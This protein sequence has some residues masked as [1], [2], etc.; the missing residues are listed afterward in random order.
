MAGPNRHRP[1]AA[2]GGATVP[3][4]R[5]RWASRAWLTDLVLLALVLLL[6]LAPRLVNLHTYSGLF[7]EGIRTEQLFLMQQGY[8]PFSQI[9][10]AQGPLLLDTLYPLYALYDRLLDPSLLAAR[11]VAVTYSLVGLAGVYWLGHQLAGRTG[12]LVAAL[13]LAL[14]P[15]YLEGSRLALAEVPAL[16]PA[17]LALGCAQR[18]SLRGASRWLWLAGLLLTMSLLMK[19]ITLA[20]APA[21]ALAALLRG[22]RGL[23][24]LVAVGLGMLALSALAIWLL[25]FS[26]VFEQIWLYRKLAQEAEPW[27]LRKNIEAIRVGLGYEPLALLPLA[28][29]GGLALLASDWRRMLPSLVWA[30]GGLALLLAYSPL[31]GKHLVVAI[32]G[33][34]LLAG[35]GWTSLTRRLVGLAPR[36][37]V[38]RLLAAVLPV[39][40]VGWYGST[41]A[42]LLPRTSEL[43][44][45]TRDDNVDPAFE[46]YADAVTTLRALTSPDDFIVTDQPYLAFLAERKVPPELVDTALTRI[47]S[48]S[49]TGGQAITTAARY[50]PKLI[51]LWG[52]RLR[53]LPTFK[54]WVD[55]N[56]QAIKVY[57]RRGDTDRAIYLRRDA[58]FTAARA[59]LDDGLDGPTA[60]FNGE[61]RLV[62]A[63]LDR[64]EV[65]SGQGAT[66]TLL[67]T[68]LRATEIDYHTLVDLR[69]ADGR[70]VDDQEESLGG[71][72][73][74]T[75]QWQP[76]RWLIQ[77]SFVVADQVPPGQY[78]VTLRLYDSKAR[79]VIAV[80]GQSE[81]RQL[82]IGKLTVRCGGGA[83]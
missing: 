69:E 7:D 49:L 29:L 44:K 16:A 77:S 66:L 2:R 22:R 76:G 24:D 74:G 83:C 13:L 39:L 8:R 52:D 62:G 4:F 71:G 27:N 17:I 43:L 30:V 60:D 42:P 70:S 36:R 47:R 1:L 41:L 48:R 12:A 35:A 63:Q 20:A 37:P 6:A 19:P 25:G 31:H 65:T 78:A 53:S 33:A 51:V 61:L 11:L 40:A 21:V 68:Q 23:R 64:A 75:G 55:R 58:D 45:V 32:P 59:A 38:G 3:A 72:S 28:G 9:F 82:E 46:Q 18:Y 81:R 5:S 67:W 79:A 14:S 80:D 54:Q 34:A 26:E 56:Y 10:A 50:D 57:N 73:D 15:L